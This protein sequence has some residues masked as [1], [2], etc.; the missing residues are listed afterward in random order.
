MEELAAV[1]D[2]SVAE[3]E[4]SAS[5]LCRAGWLV[6]IRHRRFGIADF[7]VGQLRHRFI[8]G[9]LE[10]TRDAGVV[11]WLAD[12]RVSLLAAVRMG[13]EHGPAEPAARLAS[14][15]W[16]LAPAAVGENWWPD[17][18]RWGE[19]SAIRWKNPH[20]LLDLLE[21][22]ARVFQQA[23]DFLTAETQW[24]RASAIGRQLDDDRRIGDVLDSLSEL[25]RM[26]G[27]THRLLDV[28]FMRLVRTQRLGDESAVARVLAELGSTMLTA[29]RTDSAVDYL[30]RADQ[31]FDGLRTPSPRDH[32]DVLITLGRIRW[33]LGRHAAAR[34]CF[35]RS[36]AML[37]DL[38][39]A[40]ADRVRR[41]LATRD[42]EP[43]PEDDRVTCRETGAAPTP[44]VG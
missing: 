29:D 25:Y 21:R 28:L 2:M 24:V 42:E 40:A 44:R 1:I 12:H 18:A 35:S 34:R 5:A 7:D 43:L 30:S 13:A 41:L 10:A 33:S 37:V 11:A 15:L 27:R 19:E 9:L 6:R 8:E 23:E 22:S 17:L 14:R 39:D 36:L 20:F 4:R 31:A 26:W 3:V 38:D 16:E 32:A